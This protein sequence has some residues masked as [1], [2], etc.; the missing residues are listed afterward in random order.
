MA[1]QDLPVGTIVANG[2]VVG[3]IEDSIP[4]KQAREQGLTSLNRNS[5]VLYKIDTGNKIVYRHN[6]KVKVVKPKRGRKKQALRG[7]TKTKK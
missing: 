3:R 7:T 1:G 4:M 6:S 5:G 2:N